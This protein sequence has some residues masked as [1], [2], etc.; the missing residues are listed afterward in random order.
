[1]KAAEL[2]EASLTTAEKRVLRLVSQ[3]M[4]NR[5]IASSLSISPATVK[6]HVENIFRKLH[7]RNRVEAA[8]Y[9]LSILE[10]DKRNGADCPLA[11][12]RR[13]YESRNGPIGQ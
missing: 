6:R 2:F 9:A 1:M 5:E 11:A 4:T 7:L 13:R 10:C 3:S 12:W 8:I